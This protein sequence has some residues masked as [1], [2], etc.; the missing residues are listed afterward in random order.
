MMMA[1]TIQVSDELADKL[2]SHKC[3]GESYDDVLKRLLE[4]DE[5]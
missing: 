5:L 1:T 2:Y 3:R 4:V